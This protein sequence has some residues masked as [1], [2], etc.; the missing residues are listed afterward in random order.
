[1]AVLL[2]A[3]LAGLLI[4]QMNAL[5][6]QVYSMADQE[7]RLEQLKEQGLLLESQHSLSL[8]RAQM[9]ELANLLQFQRIREITY[10]RILGGSVA[11]TTSQE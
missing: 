4:F 8:S 10:L 11:R 1:G 5:T 3:F 7:K 2:G 9:E 6:A